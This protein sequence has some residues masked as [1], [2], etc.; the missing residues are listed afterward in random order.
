MNKNFKENIMK[1]I[2]VA[3]AALTK[4]G[5]IFIAQRPADKKP[6]L[7][8]EFPG[9]KQEPG[10]TLPQT[11]KRELQEELHI[12]A[13]IGEFIAQTTHNYDFAT[14]E[15]NLFHATMSDPNAPI[16]DTEH[17]QT[18]WVYPQELKNYNFA[19]ADKVL[20]AQIGIRPT[21]KAP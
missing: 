18:A 14:V 20:I 11:L 9:G 12:T 8:W 19:E 6:P 1:K 2:T 21:K 17:C 10:E 15:I 3:A 16:V 7:V 5:K 13:Q 4:N